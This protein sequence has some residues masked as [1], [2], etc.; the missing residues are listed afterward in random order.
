MAYDDLSFSFERLD[1]YRCAVTVARW[2]RQ[3]PWPAGSAH[4]KDQGIRAAQSMVLNIAEGAS[5][6]GQP[7][8]NHFRI[9]KGSAG[10]VLAVLDLVDLPGGAEQQQLLRRIGAM[11]HRMRGR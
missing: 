8:T 5:R 9:A 1:V 7:G 10:E 4:L 6:G 2:I 3:A 11:L